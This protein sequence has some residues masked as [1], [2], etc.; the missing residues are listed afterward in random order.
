MGGLGFGSGFQRGRGVVA[1]GRVRER[2]SGVDWMGQVVRRALMRVW[3]PSRA[4][5][6]RVVLRVGWEERRVVVEGS[7][8]GSVA[9]RCARSVVYGMGFV[10]V[11]GLWRVL[12]PFCVMLIEGMCGARMCVRSF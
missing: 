4:R 6:L 8:S 1:E 5:F 9:R 3:A 2:P 10:T 7:G 11:I 12:V